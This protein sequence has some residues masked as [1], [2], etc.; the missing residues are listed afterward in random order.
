MRTGPPTMRTDSPWRRCPTSRIGGPPSPPSRL[1]RTFPDADGPRRI[2]LL[3][4]VPIWPKGS[5]VQLSFEGRTYL[6]TGGGSG[7]GKGVA[8]ALVA[9]GANVMIIG[10]TADRLATAADDIKAVGGPGAIA[11]EPADIT[12]ED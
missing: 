5:V 12:D 10:R 2:S 11:F 8:A 4:P 9:A 6:V 7:I 1:A 3:E